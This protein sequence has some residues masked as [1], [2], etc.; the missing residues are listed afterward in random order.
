MT[1]EA[2]A[3]HVSSAM[4]DYIVRLTN[5]TRKSND[6]LMGVSPRGTLALMH[7][8][9]AYACLHGRNFCIP[10]D[11]KAVAIPVLSHRLILG[12]GKSQDCDKFIQTILKTVI[13]PT[14]DFEK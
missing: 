13:V 14:E 5:E 8:A 12:Y 7:A 2:S 3:V 6:V 1:K 11:V 4:L 9:K 10:D